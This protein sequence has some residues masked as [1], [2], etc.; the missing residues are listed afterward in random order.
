MQFGEGR[1]GALSF[2]FQVM[3][4]GTQSGF[5]SLP[6]DHI[7]GNLG[8]SL[9]SKEQKDPVRVYLIMLRETFFILKNPHKN[10]TQCLRESSRRDVG[11]KCCHL[12]NLNMSGEAHRLHLPSS[13]SVG[14]RNIVFVPYCCS[15]IGWVKQHKFVA[16][17]FRSSKWGS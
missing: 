6:L 2:W 7:D 12:G 1:K 16:L 3:W 5:F 8:S 13:S 9:A 15:Q 14:T 17:L 4:R 11:L 10:L